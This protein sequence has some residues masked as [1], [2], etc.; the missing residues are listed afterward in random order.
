MNERA[1]RI[2]VLLCMLTAAATALSARGQ[3]P[4]PPPGNGLGS[5]GDWLPNGPIFGFTH[6]WGYDLPGDPGG[7]DGR[8]G[9]SHE[10]GWGGG[11]G[12][13]GEP[14]PESC[15]CGPENECNV[16]NVAKCR[17]HRPDY[18]DAWC[19]CN[20][21]MPMPR[22]QTGAVLHGSC[23]RQ[24]TPKHSPNSCTANGAPCSIRYGVTT[25]W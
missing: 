16:L 5:A 4:P 12:G 8:S 14:S 23:Y 25:K 15:S 6:P 18:C 3:T 17:A 10:G 19:S 20:V 21:K 13:G 11:T 22:P 1:I 2:A 9:W 7:S 24:V